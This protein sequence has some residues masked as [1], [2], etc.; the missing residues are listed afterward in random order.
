M[1]QDNNSVAGFLHK[2]FCGENPYILTI[3]PFAQGLILNI[4]RNL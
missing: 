3:V 2:Y 1:G 4:T